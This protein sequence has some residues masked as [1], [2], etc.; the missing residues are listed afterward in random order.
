M[1]GDSGAGEHRVG[2]G[3]TGERRA[4]SACPAA[5]AR[6]ST[7]QPEAACVSTR[8]T[9]GSACEGRRERGLEGRKVRDG[10]VG[11]NVIE[12]WRLPGI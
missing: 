1:A 3:G 2:G 6:V 8:P 5:T 4:G 11:P 9:A 7:G 12:I 10:S